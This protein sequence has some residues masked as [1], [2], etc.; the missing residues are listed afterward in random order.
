MSD[1]GM[2]FLSFTVGFIVGAALS[3]VVIAAA[4]YI[5]SRPKWTL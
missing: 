1:S 4:I 2:I 5:A 3:W